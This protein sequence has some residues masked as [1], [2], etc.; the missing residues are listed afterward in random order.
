MPGLKLKPLHDPS[1]GVLRVVGLMSGTGSNLQKIIEWGESLKS[2]RGQAVYQVVAIFTDTAG[3]RAGEIGKCHDI[4]VVIRDLEGFYAHRGRPRS[5]LQLREEFDRETVKALSPFEA[6]AAVYAG[7]MSIATRPLTE[8]YL[9][10]NVHPADLSIEVGGRRRFTGSQAVRDAIL[11]GEPFLRSTTHIVEPTVD[12]GRILMISP[13]LPVRAEG[14][15]DPRS[16]E[17]IRKVAHD[18]QERLK[19]AGDWVIFPRTL[20]YI[21][22]GRYAQDEEGQLFFDGQ[23]IPRGVRL[24]K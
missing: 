3:S 6:R 1:V 12:G 19:K 11:A 13:P 5:D 16:P 17:L 8:A 18:Y 14:G 22:E 4:P 9:G 20:Q 10:V 21:A 2:E 15:C 24:E 7:Y 23:P